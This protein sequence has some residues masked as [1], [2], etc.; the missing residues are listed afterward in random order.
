MCIRDR[1]KGIDVF[2]HQAR[3][4]CIKARGCGRDRSRVSK[5]ELG[6][7]AALGRPR[8][9]LCSGVEADYGP[10]VASDPACDLTLSGPDVEDPIEA[11]QQLTSEREDLLLILRVDALGEAAVPPIRVRFPQPIYVDHLSTFVVGHR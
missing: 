5:Y 1:F 3:D 6:A 7:T 11:V 2:E 10:D 8:D 9:Q 4:S